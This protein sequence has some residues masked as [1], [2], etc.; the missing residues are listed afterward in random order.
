VI[1][2]RAFLGSLSLTLACVRSVIAQPIKV[3]R[4]GQIGVTSVPAIDFAFLEGLNRAG[5]QEGRD[6][7]IDRRGFD[8]TPRGASM[9]AASVLQGNP[10]VIVAW[11]TVSAVAVKATGTAL[12]VVFLSVGVPVEIGLISS[13]SHPGGNMTGVTFEAATETYGKRLQVLK[14]IAPNLSRV[15][16]IHASGD[17]NVAHAMTSVRAAAQSLR[18]QILPIAIHDAPGL[19]A[20]FLAMKDQ[21]AQGFVVV[22]GALT[23]VNGKRIAELALI[24]GL[25]SCHAFRETVADGGLIGL[26]PSYNDMAAQGATFVAKI[27]KGANPGALPVEQPSKMQLVINLKTAKALALTVPPSLLL[28]ADEVIQ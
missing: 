6:F 24:H 22:A 17:S 20:A 26:G 27:M 19:E 25:P 11:G 2:R 28:R 16:I 7:V 12:P 5:Y 3:W 21:K 4:I 10:D 14:E 13:L 9:A 18:I 1:E 23:F 15:A 8:G